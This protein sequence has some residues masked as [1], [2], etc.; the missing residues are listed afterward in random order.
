MMPGQGQAHQELQ[1][2]REENDTLKKVIEQ[3]K[4]DMDAIV[5]KVKSTVND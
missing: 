4:I 3:M 5:E 2:L 1:F